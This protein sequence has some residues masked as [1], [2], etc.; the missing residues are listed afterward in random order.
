MFQENNPC[1][2][3]IVKHIFQH[4]FFPLQIILQTNLP[5]PLQNQECPYPQFPPSP[6]PT[7]L[8]KS[9]FFHAIKV[10]KNNKPIHLNHKL[11]ENNKINQEIIESFQKIP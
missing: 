6:H 11:K 10:W 2:K 4:H 5:L 8:S 1:Q 9:L 3:P 7:P